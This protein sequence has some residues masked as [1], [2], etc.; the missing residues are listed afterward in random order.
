MDAM[1]KRRMWKVAVAHFL[2]TL[3]VAWKLIHYSAWSGPYEREIWFMAWGSFWL[4]VFVMFQPQL[5]LFNFVTG[6]LVHLPS[7]FGQ[8]VF[9]ASVPIWSLCFGWILVRLD[10]WLNHFPVLGKRVL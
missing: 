6:F 1:Q 2:L 9:I 5:L 8:L 7:W 10:K 4:K 3:F